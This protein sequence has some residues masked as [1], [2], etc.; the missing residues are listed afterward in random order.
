MV[1][2][3]RPSA[4]TMSCH[5]AGTDPHVLRFRP[6]ER[7]ISIGPAVRPLLA[8]RV[9]P[10]A[11]VHNSVGKHTAG[12]WKPD[13]NSV[14]SR[15]LPRCPLAYIRKPPSRSIACSGRRYGR[16]LRRGY[17]RAGWTMTDPSFAFGCPS[18]R[19]T[20]HTVQRMDERIEGRSSKGPRWLTGIHRLRPLGVGSSFPPGRLTIRYSDEFRDDS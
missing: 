3:S 7:S 4:C 11:D 10:S 13:W 16:A 1:K 14:I 8:V 2:L 18:S 5:C 20:G 6:A 17:N 9:R 19:R 15:Y 12:S